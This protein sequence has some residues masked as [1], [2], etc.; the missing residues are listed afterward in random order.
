MTARTELCSTVG[1]SRKVFDV[2]DII[3][4]KSD[5]K[6]TDAYMFDGEVNM[7]HDEKE[8]CTIKMLQAEFS[9]EF[10]VVKRGCLVR[11]SALL[12]MT[13]N[14]NSSGMH[15]AVLA[16]GL[17]VAVSRREVP[18]IRKLLVARDLAE[19]ALREPVKETGEENAQD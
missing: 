15:T 1:R 13:R 6:Y 2:S 7:L 4:F 17:Y 10:V 9:D 19:L 18:A 16:N 14:D 12:D 8:N 11:R 3:M 5:H